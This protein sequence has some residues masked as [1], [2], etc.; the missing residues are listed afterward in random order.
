MA[1]LSSV[2]LFLNDSFLVSE[3]SVFSEHG[4]YANGLLR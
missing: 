1:A 3:I 2:V 4:F